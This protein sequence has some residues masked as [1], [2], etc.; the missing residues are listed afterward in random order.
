MAFLGFQ[1]ERRHRT[2]IQTRQRDRLARFL[3]I[4]VLVFFDPANRS[5]YLGD[6]LALAISRPQL[7][8][9][10]GFRRRPI[11]NIRQRADIFLKIR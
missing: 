3:A 6:Q 7:Q 2:C 9:T 5:F 1:A 10:V 11:C 8:R 4:S